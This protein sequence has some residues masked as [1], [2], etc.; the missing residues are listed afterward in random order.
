MKI[1]HALRAFLFDIIAL[2]SS[3]LQDLLE[4]HSRSLDRTALT[5]YSSQPEPFL[6][7]KLSA[8]IFSGIWRAFEAEF[9]NYQQARFAILA[10]GPRA[11]APAPNARCKEI[12]NDLS[13]MLA[14]TRPRRR[15][16]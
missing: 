4:D 12:A 3:R 16:A 1:A 5:A 10:P 8:S 2:P 13:R 6:K 14:Q 15:N 11:I 7:S 9:E